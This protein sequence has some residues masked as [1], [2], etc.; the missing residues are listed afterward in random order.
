MNSQ[1]WTETPSPPEAE[2][3]KSGFASQFAIFPDQQQANNIVET[4]IPPQDQFSVALGEQYA[5]LAKKVNGLKLETC[6]PE[7]VVMPCLASSAG[8]A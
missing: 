4:L 8:A 1:N 5:E 2:G 3:L 6:A 7:S